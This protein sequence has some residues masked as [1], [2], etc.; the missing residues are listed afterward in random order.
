[1]SS[2]GRKG[3]GR[4]RGVLNHEHN[5]SRATDLLS[6]LREERKHDE[7]HLNTERM[8]RGRGRGNM[9]VKNGIDKM[10]VVFASKIQENKTCSVQA[11]T[12][13]ILND[14]VPKES[15]LSTADMKG[16]N[17]HEFH[18]EFAKAQE[19]REEQTLQQL[20]DEM[21]EDMFETE[22]ERE[23]RL[24]R[25]RREERA[26]K[27][28][29][30]RCM[31]EKE[32]DDINSSNSSTTAPLVKRTKLENPKEESLVQQPDQYP[33]GSSDHKYDDDPQGPLQ[34]NEKI[35]DDGMDSFDM[36]TSSVTPP[37]K[38]SAMSGKEKVSIVATATTTGLGLDD[39]EGYY[40]ASIG[41]IISFTKDD[42]QK[43]SFRVLGIIGKGV[44]S[45]VLKCV[46][47][48]TAASS[49]LPEDAT[50]NTATNVERFVA[51]K[52]I[53]SNET[54]TKAAMKEVRILRLLQ[55]IP[56]NQR[57]K[58]NV[59]SHEH[60]IVRMIE[61][62][63]LGFQSSVDDGSSSS[64][65]SPIGSMLEYHNHTAI[66]FE[67]FPYNLRETLSKF[68]KNVGINLSA[69]RSY[70]KQLMSALKHLADHR[71]VHADIK[72]DNILVSEN[73][74]VVKLCDFGSAFFETDTDNVPTPYLV[75]LLLFDYNHQMIFMLL[76]YS[77]FESMESFLN[78]GI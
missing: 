13:S 26:Q 66:L 57:K 67:Y 17:D 76:F 43:M 71:V 33:M 35:N 65:I 44:F 52:L 58:T 27:L 45:T 10:D 72:L 28:Q 31:E 37:V 55:T 30:L 14:A 21:E 50:E 46:H 11:E 60:Y 38:D 3:R 20:V 9:A 4:G 25:K 48:P 78:I 73:F 61:G 24:A 42:S 6:P 34:H 12:N 15:A 22:E 75:R 8:G 59:G 16:T 1:M 77:H 19:L 47:L 56:K 63:E 69:V 23:E 70:S 36:F 68:G 39:A 62:D 74:S 54:M 2:F 5:E 32:V 18:D 51:M 64:D 7:Y 40:K 29:R 49:S 53:R 41:E